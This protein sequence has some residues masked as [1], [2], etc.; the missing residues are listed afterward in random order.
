MVRKKKARKPGL[1]IEGTGL[2]YPL[3]QVIALDDSRPLLHFDEREDGS[4]DIR[5]SAGLIPDLEVFTGFTIHRRESLALWHGE[6]ELTDQG[7]LL[8]LARVSPLPLAH[9]YLHLN[10]LANGRWRMVYGDGV[11]LDI[12]LLTGVTLF[13]N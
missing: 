11:L 3:G 2:S 1:V 5:Y 13:K 4:V 8:Q 12:E 7:D 6:V 10:Q 9:F